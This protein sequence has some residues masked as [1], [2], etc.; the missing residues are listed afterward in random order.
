[1]S[2]EQNYHI[3]NQLNRTPPA[4]PELLQ[5]E[6][7]GIAQRSAHREYREKL[8]QTSVNFVNSVVIFFLVLCSVENPLPGKRPE[9]R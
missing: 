1:L 9:K 5:S 3:L 2:T 7:A 8:F 4:T 6:K